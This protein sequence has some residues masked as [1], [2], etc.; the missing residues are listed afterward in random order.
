M[1]AERADSARHCR[2]WGS[3]WGTPNIVFADPG[4]NANGGALPGARGIASPLHQARLE[5]ESGL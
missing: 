5:A 4:R 1:E 2:R 3:C